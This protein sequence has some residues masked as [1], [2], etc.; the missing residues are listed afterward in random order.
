MHTMCAEVMWHKQKSTLVLKAVAPA[1][2]GSSTH[3]LPNE[4]AVLAA[5]S[6]DDTQSEVRVPTFTTRPVAICWNSSISL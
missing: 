5:S 1:P 3:G 6:M 4:L 2:T